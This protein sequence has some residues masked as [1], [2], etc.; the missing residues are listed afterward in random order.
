[1]PTIVNINTILFHSSSNKMKHCL[2]TQGGGAAAAESS[3]DDDEEE[4][5]DAEEDFHYEMEEDHM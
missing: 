5:V 4:D 3:D 1:M 2:P